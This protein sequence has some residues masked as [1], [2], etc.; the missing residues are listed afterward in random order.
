[1]NALNLTQ[2]QRIDYQTNITI[3]GKP[4]SMMLVVH[5][6]AVADVVL[7]HAP[8]TAHIQDGRRGLLQSLGNI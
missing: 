2:L 4:S 8:V 5:L 6:V 7:L 3:A 1:M